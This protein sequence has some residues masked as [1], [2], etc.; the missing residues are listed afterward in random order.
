[1][2]QVEDSTRSEYGDKDFIDNHSTYSVWDLSDYLFHWF[3]GFFLTFLFRISQDFLRQKMK[4]RQKSIF[5]VQ[6]NTVSTPP[7]Q[8]TIPCALPQAVISLIKTAESLSSQESSWPV[9]LKVLL[10][11]QL[12]HG[13][14]I[15]EC[16]RIRAMDLLSL[17]R[18]K[19]N[20]LKGSQ[21]RVISFNDEFGYLAMCRKLSISP[22]ADYSRFFIY[23]L[24]RANSIQLL[25]SNSTKFA[26][27]HCL[28]HAMAQQLTSEVNDT[29]LVQ[30][31]LRHKSANSTK[32]YNLKK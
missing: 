17:N 26:V 32:W 22:F 16:L 27:T 31:A 1:M 28:R 12:E 7:A 11:L 24:Y 10:R 13:L 21:N 25:T 18:I 14:R 20:S 9:P 3:L 30:D 4:K 19:I 5:E 15:T 8:S 6:D 2:Q 29:E 23:R